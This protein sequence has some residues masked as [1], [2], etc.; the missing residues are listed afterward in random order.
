MNVLVSFVLL[1]RYRSKIIVKTVKLQR[2]YVAPMTKGRNS[3][4]SLGS[5]ILIPT[6]F[7]WPSMSTSMFQNVINQLLKYKPNK[8][9]A[10]SMVNFDRLK[11]TIAAKY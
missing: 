2:H 7:L 10:Y 4:M 11:T 1:P 5:S 8:L 6:H 3:A 9:L